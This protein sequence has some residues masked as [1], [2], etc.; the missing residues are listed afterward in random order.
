MHRTI[1]ALL[2][3]TVL[4]A[5]QP[6][7]TVTPTAAPSATLTPK[8]TETPTATPTET[9]PVL[10][11]DKPMTE[12]YD[13]HN[14]EVMP[15]VDKNMVSTGGLQATIDAYWK[16][17]LE[18]SVYDSRGN[19]ILP[20]GVIPAESNGWKI[21][22]DQNAKSTAIS[23]ADYGSINS[24]GFESSPIRPSNELFKIEGTNQILV[25]E[26]LYYR[27]NEENLKVTPVFFVVDTT[28]TAF[29]IK[30]NYMFG[31]PLEDHR[32]YGFSLPILKYE[33][34]PYSKTDPNT[35]IFLE[36]FAAEA[37]Q[38]ERDKV[39]ASVEN[40]TFNP[41]DLGKIWSA[42]GAFLWKK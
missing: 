27:D 36:P 28:E 14:L 4:S 37:M 13:P 18:D 2:V 33:E 11:L 10:T 31:R 39:L 1:Y 8:P 23:W 19:V 29:K 25:T 21:T 22:I 6:V 40:G 9:V 7:V 30:M 15:T 38:Q 16:S 17:N 20:P 42:P 3:L 32:S 34:N 26:R 24:L 35:F 12:V 41:S 5:C